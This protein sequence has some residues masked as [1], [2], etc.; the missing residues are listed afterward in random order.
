MQLTSFIGR[1]DEIAQINNLL[2]NAPLVT[3]TGSGG[4]GKTRLAHEIG[5]ANVSVYPDG[6]W[7][8]GLAPLSDPKL[9]VEEVTSV[10]GVGEEALFDYLEDKSTLLILDNCEHMLDACAELAGTLLQRAPEIRVLATS[11]EALGIPGETVHRVPSLPVPDS[12]QPSIEALSSYAAV[13]LFAERAATVQPGFVL[14]ELKAEPV[15]HITQQLDG[16]PLAIELA[17][18]RVNVLSAAQ[19]ADRLDDAFRLLT[20]GSRTAL[21]R[22]QTLLGALEWSYELLSGPE[23][24]FFNRLSVFRGGFTLEAAEQV[25]SGDGLESYEVL[26]VLSQLIDKSLVVVEQDSGSEARYRLLEVLRLYGAE[27]LAET[28]R[29][30]DVRGRHASFFLTVAE[31]AGPELATSKQVLWLDRLESDYDNF[32]AAMAW[33]LESNGGETALRI[34]SELTW[35][36]IYHRHVSDGQEWLERVV[37]HS[38][39]APPTLRA[40]GLARAAL[41]HGK[42]LKDYE[43]LRGW[44]EETCACARKRYRPKAWW[45]C[46]G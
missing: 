29:T 17:A 46:S 20:K 45:R 37:Q 34:A 43:R 2:S 28:G 40:I 16:I 41:L 35:F 33:A 1:E 9:I 27:R 42:K 31:R 14:T 18:A 21:P 26:D 24:V 3:L 36:W 4:A 19:I 22:H 8:V 38:E 6:V 15:A 13:R 32:R 30:E 5:S 44:L 25:C 10:L 23:R 11:Q 7:L 39:D 12:P